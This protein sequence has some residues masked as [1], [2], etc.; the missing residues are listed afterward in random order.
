MF[1]FVFLCL[2]IAACN[3]LY[4][5]EHKL[6]IPS[7]AHAGFVATGAGD[8]PATVLALGTG[9]KCLGGSLR[10]LTGDTVNDS[11]AEAV[12]RRALQRWLRAELDELLALPGRQSLVLE[13]APSG[14]WQVGGR[15]ARLKSG[16]QL[17]MVI[18][19]PPCGDACITEQQRPQAQ[20]KPAQQ[21][22]SSTNT[23]AGLSTGAKRLQLGSS[24]SAV[25]QAGDVEACPE[26]GVLRRK[27]G[28]GDATLS[29]SCS[30]KIS[31][32]CCL[33]LQV[34]MYIH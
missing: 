10:S 8:L 14:G 2:V 24:C 34:G 32:W 27:P 31:R 29:M 25:P 17:H 33:G 16:V 22:S 18:T 11:H 15:L 30:D 3:G 26:P 1:P 9:T 20:H 19:Y 23:A 21:P 12:A 6:A 5:H 28:R 13:L 7:L 4:M